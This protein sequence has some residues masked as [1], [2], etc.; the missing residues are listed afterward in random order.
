MSGHITVCLEVKDDHVS[1]GMHYGFWAYNHR[2]IIPLD[3]M[4]KRSEARIRLK[5]CPDCENKMFVDYGFDKYTMMS[6]GMDYN[7]EYPSAK[8]ACGWSGKIYSV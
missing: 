4:F 2:F 8:H 7:Q 1:I 3:A 5:R 6:C